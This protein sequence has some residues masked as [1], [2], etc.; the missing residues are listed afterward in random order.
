MTSDES[1]TPE[2]EYWLLVERNRVI[3]EGAGA[4][5]VAAALSGRAG[6]GRIACVVSGG[7]VDFDVLARV[8]LG[9]SAE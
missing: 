6:E 5:P 8:V 2:E 7:N 4:A 9:R 1:A 3:V